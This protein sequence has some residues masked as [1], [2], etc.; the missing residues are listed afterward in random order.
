MTDLSECYFYQSV[1]LPVHGLQVGEWD[2]RDHMDEYLGH[3]DVDGRRVLELGTANGYL[4]FEMERRGAEVVAYDLDTSDQWDIVP[5]DG[6]VPDA[7]RADRR[8]LIERLHSAWWLTHRL[9]E[10]SARIAYGN[11]YEIPSALG[12]FDV[13]TFGSI[14]QHVRDPLLAMQRGAAVADEAVIVTD[15]LRSRR[16]ER[17]ARHLQRVPVL[18]A[19]LTV[20]PKM[21]FVPDPTT[22]T[23]NDTWWAIS[24]ELIGRVL[25]VLGFPRQAVTFHSQTYRHPT[26]RQIPMFTVVARR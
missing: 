12:R 23:P 7:V 22:D 26:T 6:I 4:C 24:P 8:A 9:R 3:I 15:V 10:S 18:G 13:V 5:F 21:A 20:A 1:D 16:T 25:A 14:L 17:L 11:I 2:L 19:R